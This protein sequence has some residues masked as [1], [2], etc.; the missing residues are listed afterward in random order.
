LSLLDAIGAEGVKGANCA[1]CRHG[2]DAA[3]PD[4]SSDTTAGGEG[5]K[6]VAG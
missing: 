5:G 1:T 6:D 4:V 2:R 3:S